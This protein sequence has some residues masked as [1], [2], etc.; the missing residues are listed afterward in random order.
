MTE[1]KNAIESTYSR[2]DLMED[3]LS[4]LEDRNSDIAPS[5]ENKAKRMKE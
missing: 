2:V 3:R 4:Y 5:E 1:M